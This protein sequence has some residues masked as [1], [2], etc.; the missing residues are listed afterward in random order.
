MTAVPL[1]SLDEVS[2]DYG[3]RRVL[4]DI[5][6]TVAHGDRVALMGPSGSGKT[7]LLNCIGGIDRADTGRVLFEGTDLR[8]LDD[9]DLARV[10]R[11]LIGT[12]FQFFHLLPTLTV[13]EN[14]E[15]PLRLLGYSQK[16]REARVLEL[17]SRV[18]LAERADSFPSKLSGGEQQRIAIARAVAHR[19][20]LIIA[21]EP[22]GNL[23]SKSGKRVLEL[24][25][26][27]LKETAAT[28]VLVTHSE[29]T[30]AL[31]ERRLHLRDG[32]LV[33]PGA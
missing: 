27:V 28:L 21:D 10:R 24:L 30:A 17:L 8:A 25:D 6:L 2:K 1:L 31:C 7:T 12:V 29:A 3:Q 26:E 11:Q 20:R 15:L 19:P 23:D 22:T 33:E 9:E 16:E 13:A 5:T 32:Q 18:E 14:V 4:K